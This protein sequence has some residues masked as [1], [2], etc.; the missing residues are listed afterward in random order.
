MN[1]KCHNPADPDYFWRDLNDG[2][3]HARLD[4]PYAI[5]VIFDS[6]VF[7][8]YDNVSGLP[9][10]QWI[11]VDPVAYG[12]DWANADGGVSILFPPLRATNREWRDLPGMGY[13][14][15][16]TL[17]GSWPWFGVAATGGKGIAGSDFVI[18]NVVVVTDCMGYDAHLATPL[19]A[20]IY[21]RA[22]VTLGTPPGLVGDA[23]YLDASGTVVVCSTEQGA[24][25]SPI[26]GQRQTTISAAAK[27]GATS[28]QL[29]ST[30]GIAAGMRLSLQ[31][32][33]PWQREWFFTTVGMVNE[34]SVTFKSGDSLPY[35]VTVGAKAT[36]CNRSGPK[37]TWW[38]D[39]VAWFNTN[40]E[41]QQI[42]T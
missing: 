36:A 25:T 22:N 19:G 1:S 16:T 42:V 15:T 29:A 27:A 5:P 9:D 13:F 34:N 4:H 6:N 31:V 3:G 40:G 11:T 41:Q 26:T 37:P 7:F 28:V 10:T 21:Q 20:Q 35:G 32:N 12:T 23:R 30:S 38:P 17:H 18:P 14:D 8:P 24:R 2:T 39:I 33:G